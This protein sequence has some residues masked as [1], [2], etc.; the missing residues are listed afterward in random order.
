MSLGESAHVCLFDFV[1]L[2]AYFMLLFRYTHC[3]IY[4]YILQ[5]IILILSGSPEGSLL[6]FSVQGGCGWGEEGTKRRP[7]GGVLAPGPPKEGTTAAGRKGMATTTKAKALAKTGAY[8]AHRWLWRMGRGARLMLPSFDLLTLPPPINLP[9]SLRPFFLFLCSLCGD[10]VSCY[11]REL[12]RLSN[13]CDSPPWWRKIHGHPLLWRV[14]SPRFSNVIFSWPISD[15][16][17]PSSWP[18]MFLV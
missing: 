7:Q 11:L 10:G 8:S 5:D 12:S 2:G 17:F 15:Q 3:R 6:C 14:F 1:S 18:L 16:D 9:L 13:S 4:I